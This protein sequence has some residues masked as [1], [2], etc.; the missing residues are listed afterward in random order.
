MFAVATGH[1]GCY[2]VARNAPPRLGWSGLPA[3]ADSFIG[4]HA[5]R[6]AGCSGMALTV[7]CRVSQGLARRLHV[8]LPAYWFVTIC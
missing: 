7:P 4:G 1:S 6:G 2:T 8:E 5:D 3:Q